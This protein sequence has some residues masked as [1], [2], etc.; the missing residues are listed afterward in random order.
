V[1]LG[2]TE[3]QLTTVCGLYSLSVK[4]HLRDGQ[5]DGQSVRP[6]RQTPGIEF[7][8][9]LTSGGNNFNEFPDN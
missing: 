7:G 2:D 8:A 9:F 5:M 6:D 4:L 3:V 1:Q